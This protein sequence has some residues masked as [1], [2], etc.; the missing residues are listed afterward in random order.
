MS[1]NRR[2]GPLPSTEPQRERAEPT[3]G[4]DI[5]VVY[6]L[7]RKNEQKKGKV[8]THREGDEDDDE[9]DDGLEDLDAR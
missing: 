3:S 4:P 6:C 2:P 5:V 1:L 9:D 7:L 8:R